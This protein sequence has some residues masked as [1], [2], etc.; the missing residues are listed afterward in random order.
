MPSTLNDVLI[1]LP[2]A[3]CVLCTGTYNRR[4]GFNTSRASTSWLG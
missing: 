4:R 3:V 1:F 2:S